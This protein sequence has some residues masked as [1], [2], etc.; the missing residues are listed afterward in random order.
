[1]RN[2]KIRQAILKTTKGIAS[3]LGEFLLME[4]QVLETIL[5]TPAGSMTMSNL[6]RRIS[7]RLGLSPNFRRTQNVVSQAKKKGWISND[8]KLTKQGEKRL[9]EIFPS[10]QKPKKWNGK[11][12]L[13]IFD[14][15]EKL[16]YKRDL[17]RQKLKQLGFGQLQQS[18]WISPRNYLLNVA[19]IIETYN[20]GDYVIFSMTEKIGLERSQDLAD[21]IWKLYRI[22]QEYKEFIE[23]YSSLEKIPKFELKID[24]LSILKKDPQLPSDLLPSDWEGETA[25]NLYQKLT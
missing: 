11:W 16:K 19:K 8:L 12:Y 1:M 22:N 25:F 4:A 6:D 14:I 7:Q 5:T 21:R 15:P 2:K 17:L 10:Y 3:H 20:L 9:K 24:F 23:K 18:V 13:V